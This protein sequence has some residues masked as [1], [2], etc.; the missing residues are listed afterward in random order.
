MAFDYRS[1]LGVTATQSN[2]PGVTMIHLPDLPRGLPPR[3]KKKKKEKFVSLLPLHEKKGLELRFAPFSLFTSK[4]F[5]MSSFFLS[6][7]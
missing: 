1:P 3:K 6:F 4:I 5:S 2:Q 7:F